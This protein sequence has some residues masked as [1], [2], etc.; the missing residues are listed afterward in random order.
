MQNYFIW[1]PVTGVQIQSREGNKSTNSNK[2]NKLAAKKKPQF[3][4]FQ[5]V[6]QFSENKMTVWNMYEM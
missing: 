1:D 4:N 3:E 5:I 6:E 2:R